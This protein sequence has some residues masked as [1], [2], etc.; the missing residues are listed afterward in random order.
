[1]R[2][3]RLV[4]A[5]EPLRQLVRPSTHVRVSV[6]AEATRARELLGDEVRQAGYEVRRGLHLTGEHAR[7]GRLGAEPDDEL[8]RD[9]TQL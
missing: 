8:A 9:G 3:L 6:L 2:G 5:L 4:R 7:A 1:M